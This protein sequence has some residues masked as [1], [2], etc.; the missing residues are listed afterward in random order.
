MQCDGIFVPGGFG[1]RGID[2]KCAA[3]KLA[4]EHDI[5]YLGVCLGM[6][7]AL[8]EFARDVLHWHDANSE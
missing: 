8:I 4:R 2:G 3:V 5:P 7:V 6:Q 1:I